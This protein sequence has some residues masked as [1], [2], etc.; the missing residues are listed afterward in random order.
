MAS[1]IRKK[2]DSDLE[3]ELKE[4]RKSL[5]Q[6]RFGSSGSKVRN[7]K[8][9]VSLRRGIARILTELQARRSEKIAETAQSK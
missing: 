7:V 6:F 1:D 8:E 9:G 5:Q 4:K 3:K 2:S